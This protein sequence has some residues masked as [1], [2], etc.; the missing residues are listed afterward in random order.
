MDAALARATVRR[1]RQRQGP[2][3]PGSWS[4][5]SGGRSARPPA[6]ARRSN[7]APGAL[8]RSPSPSAAAPAPDHW[9]QEVEGT[10]T[11]RC[12]DLGVCYGSRGHLALPPAPLE[13]QRH[14]HISISPSAPA[15]G[16]VDPPAVLAPVRGRWSFLLWVNG[17]LASGV[18]GRRAD[19]PRPPEAA[20]I[21]GPGQGQAVK[22]GR[23][24]P[25]G[26]CLE[27]VGQGRVSPT[28]R[29]PARNRRVQGPGDGK[30]GRPRLGRL[31]VQRQQ[32][33]QAPR[34]QAEQELKAQERQ[35][36]GNLHEG[37]QA[38][39]GSTT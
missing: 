12:R 36:L 29:P 35:L 23:R 24:P 30:G 2:G 21:A 9:L 31:G 6:S 10:L 26:A 13:R 28:G 18:R 37:L 15:I 19:A 17:P 3:R 27:A 34:E 25:G 5:A 1:S 20:G 4:R 14:T 39:Q 11:S 32:Q 33:D 38:V 16:L 8:L 22:T 7:P